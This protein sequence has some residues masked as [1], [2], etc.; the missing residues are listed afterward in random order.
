[1]AAEKT[2]ETRERGA[3]DVGAGDAQGQAQDAADH[4]DH[5]GVDQELHDDVAPRRAHRAP[6]ADL[7]GAL[8]HRDEHDVGHADAAHDQA[9]GGDRGHEAREGLGARRDGRRD[10]ARVDDLEVV[11]LASTSGRAGCA[12]SSAPRPGRCSRPTARPARGSAR[13]RGERRR[14][15]LRS[16]PRAR[17]RSSRPRRSRRRPARPARRSPG[18]ARRPRRRSD[19]PR[20]AAT[21]S[22]SL[23][24]VLPSTAT[25][26][27]WLESKSLKKV[28]ASTVRWSMLVICGRGAAD[29]LHGAGRAQRHGGVGVHRCD[30]R[31]DAGGG[32]DGGHVARAERH[33]VAHEA[34]CS[35]R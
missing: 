33:G 5:D 9:D 35:R 11:L 3:A 13:C 32:V 6:H 7:A 16:R 23:A 1:M 20:A 27:A 24:T 29:R 12:A 26:S 22:R 2:G 28:P 34:G 15:G 4:A 19:P 8:A 10:R 17:A 18:T 21:G 31:L 25:G 14:A 30:R